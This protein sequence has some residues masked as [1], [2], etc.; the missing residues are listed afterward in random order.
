GFEDRICTEE[1]TFRPMRRPAAW[2]LARQAFKLIQMQL[3]Q[4]LSRQ[5]LVPDEIP[6]PGSCLRHVTSSQLMSALLHQCRRQQTTMYGA[7]SAAT[8]Q[9]IAAHQQW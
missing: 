3:R 7:L 6:F 8:V 4:L 5:V 2:Y 9:V 1:M